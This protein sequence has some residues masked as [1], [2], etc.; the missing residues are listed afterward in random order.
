MERLNFSEEF[1][2]IIKRMLEKDSNK[3]FFWSD[4]SKQTLWEG[5]FPDA[6][7]F[8][9]K[10]VTPPKSSSNSGI[11]CIIQPEVKV[12]N[13]K[14]NFLRKILKPLVSAIIILIKRKLMC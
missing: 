8:E 3:R 14:P 6:D 10:E 9:K 5:P 11:N 1:V 4:L 7:F 12:E 13:Y 2:D